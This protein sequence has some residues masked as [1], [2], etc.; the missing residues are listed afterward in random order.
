VVR[1][2]PE[3]DSPKDIASL[4]VVVGELA[5][6]YWRRFSVFAGAGDSLSISTCIPATCGDNTLAIAVGLRDSK[7]NFLADTEVTPGQPQQLQCQVPEDGVYTVDVRGLSGTGLHLSGVT[8]L[9]A[10]LPFRIVS[11]S[12]GDKGSLEREALSQVRFEFSSP[13]WLPSV[14]PLA[15]KIGGVEALSASGAGNV[16]KRDDLRDTLMKILENEDAKHVEAFFPVYDVLIIVAPHRRSV[17]F[18]TLERAL[19]AV[20]KPLGRG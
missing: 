20:F 14:H 3:F 1:Q 11:T 2:V 12:P 17:G 15:L 18:A 4:P 10:L 9:T 13:V 6:G 19:P 16:V 8:G 5:A 7:W